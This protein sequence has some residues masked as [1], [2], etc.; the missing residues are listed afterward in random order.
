MDITHNYNNGN[1]RIKAEVRGKKRLA[2]KNSP[3]GSIAAFAD[4]ARISKG[5][6][7]SAERPKIIIIDKTKK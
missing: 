7:R 3:K 2:A 6:I 5:F 1:G 4:K